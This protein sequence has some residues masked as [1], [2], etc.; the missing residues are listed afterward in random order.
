MQTATEGIT[1]LHA[2]K[3]TEANIETGGRR[4]KEKQTN[5]LSLLLYNDKYIIQR[6]ISPTSMACNVHTDT[7]DKLLGTDLL[8]R[9]FHYTNCWI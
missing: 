8:M 4:E 9:T 6:I 5:K 2:E 7:V 1:Y 3:E